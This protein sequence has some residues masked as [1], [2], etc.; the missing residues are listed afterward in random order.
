[1]GKKPDN[2]RDVENVRGMLRNKD[3]QINHLKKELARAQKTQ[4]K[5]EALVDNLTDPEKQ[6][7][8]VRAKALVCPKCGSEKYD[9]VD[10]QKAGILAHCTECNYRKR[11][12]IK[13]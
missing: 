8:P 13:Q 7:K 2:S 6:F 3:K 5:N 4:K 10:L 9:E 1:M 11:L 12:T